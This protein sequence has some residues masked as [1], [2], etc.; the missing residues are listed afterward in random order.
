MRWHAFAIGLGL[1]VHFTARAAFGVVQTSDGHTLIGELHLSNDVL[2]VTS[3]NPPVTTVAMTNLQS[4]RFNSSAEAS[5]L[6][7]GGRGSGLLGY[8][9][10]NTNLHGTVGVRLDDTVDF[11]WSVAEPPPGDQFSV[12]WMGELEAPATG[13]YTFSIEAGDRGRL[14][15]ADQLIVE[16]GEHREV[17]EAAGS[18]FPLEGGKKYPLKFIDF[19]SSR[20]GRA[21]LFW[22]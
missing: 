22:S 20:E 4:A 10:S 9:F 1:T 18:P 14:Y 6:I 11:D 15:L 16:A 7:S 5:G 2:I 13:D 3:T 19:D 17:V 8:Y 12:V 21:R